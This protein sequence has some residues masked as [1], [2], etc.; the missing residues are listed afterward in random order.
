LTAEFQNPLLCP[1]AI[2]TVALAMT[3]AG[4]QPAEAR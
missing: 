4:G 3:L 2:G 1:T